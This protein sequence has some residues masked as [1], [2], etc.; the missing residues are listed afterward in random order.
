MPIK[1]KMRLN[2]SKSKLFFVFLRTYPNYSMKYNGCML[3]CKSLQKDE[4][5]SLY[6]KKRIII[7]L[8]I[9]LWMDVFVNVF[10]FVLSSGVFQLCLIW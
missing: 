8:K 10:E 7:S 9:A 4:K 6:E 1:R 2:H 3:V 5:S